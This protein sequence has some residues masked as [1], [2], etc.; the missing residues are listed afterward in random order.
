MPVTTRMIRSSGE[1]KQ[2]RFPSLTNWRNFH[3][4]SYFDRLAKLEKTHNKKANSS[5]LIL[6]C[7]IIQAGFWC[8]DFMT[9]A[10]NSSRFP[11]EKTWTDQCSNPT[12]SAPTPRFKFKT[13]KSISTSLCKRKNI[14]WIII[15]QIPTRSRGPRDLI[16]LKAAHLHIGILPPRASEDLD[17]TRVVLLGE[18]RHL[19]VLLDLFV[20]ISSFPGEDMK[21]FSTNTRFQVFYIKTNHGNSYLG[22]TT[23]KPFWK[24]Q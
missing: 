12:K 14:S 15:N 24:Q 10:G 21:I 7:H 8:V 4:L 19:W 16:C 5:W 3:F 23:L 1:P 18:W 17:F 20:V 2:N 22:P 13:N 6:F 9:S 11:K